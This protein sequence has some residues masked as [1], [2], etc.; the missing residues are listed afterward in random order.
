MAKPFLKPLSI[1]CTDTDCTNN[2]HCF[3]ATKKL[4]SRNLAGKCRECG[5]DLVDWVRV[6]KCD[7]AD[8]AYTLGALEYEL[9]RHHYWHVQFDQRALNY[10]R[11]KGW[12]K[13]RGAVRHRI[14]KSVAVKS[15]WDGRQTPKFG[16]PIFYAQHATAS[17]CRTCIEEWHG[18]PQDQHLDANQIEYLSDLC[19]LYLKQ[20][21]PPLTEYG[22]RVPPMRK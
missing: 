20:R 6:H 19:F 14:E 16:N 10:A 4:D 1:K 17:C 22:E 11:R 9:I 3:R 5:A 15:A 21:L 12:I 8:A 13:L 2:L 18:I 7:P